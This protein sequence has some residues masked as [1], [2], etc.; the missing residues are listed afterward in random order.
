MKHEPLAYKMRPEVIEEVI[1]QKHLLSEEKPLFQMINKEHLSSMILYGRPGV[2]KTSIANAFAGST[3]LR[4]R[5]LNATSSNK[6][7]LEIVVNEAKMY[8]ETI[9]LCVDEI[10]RFS[11]TQIEFLLPHIEK[12][13]LILIGL[14]SENPYH[15][16]NPAIRSRCL[17]FELQP[18][19]KSEIVEGLKR[20]VEDEEKG[21]GQYELDVEDNTLQVIA[22]ISGGDMRAA[23]NKLEIS[24]LSSEVDSNNRVPITVETV[25]NSVQKND[26]NI[27]KT[28]DGHY[29]VL[30][31]FHK[32]IRGGDADAACLMLALLIEAGDLVGISR[33]ILCAAYEDV[34]LAKPEM[35]ERALA[36]IQTAERLGFPEARIPLANIVIELCLSPKSNRAYM[37]INE[38]ISYVQEGKRITIPDHL[39]DAHYKGAEKLGHG[40]EYKYPHHYPI[41]KFGGWVAQQ[42]LPSGME[43]IGFYDPIEAGQEEKFKKVYEKLKE[44]QLRQLK[45]N[46]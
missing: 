6:K 44:E 16:I 41:G 42:Y 1:G 29:D 11:K 45:K 9:V 27:D 38:A 17:I 43:N 35:G 2:G 5:K 7:D 24:F 32:S 19:T 23:L 36:A 25:K 14:T 18:L 40:N 10:H 22:D 8:N 13:L 26:L 4:F 21:L 15:N 28:G 33:R 3:G 37:A 31:G 30:S 20:A 46:N 39:K 34:G 12:G